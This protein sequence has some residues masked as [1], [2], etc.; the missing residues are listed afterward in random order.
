[1]PSILDTLKR[2]VINLFSNLSNSSALYICVN[3]ICFTEVPKLR[4]AARKY[5]ERI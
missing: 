5:V 1:M 2:V 3:I 4:V